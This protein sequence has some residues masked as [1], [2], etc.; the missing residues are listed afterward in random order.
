MIWARPPQ[1]GAPY[2]RYVYASILHTAGPA[3]PAHFVAHASSLQRALRDGLAAAA[4]PTSDT[5]AS[6]EVWRVLAECARAAGGVDT[7]N[8]QRRRG[9]RYA[10]K[11]K[12]LIDAMRAVGCKYSRAPRAT[13]GVRALY[14]QACPPLGRACG[15]ARLV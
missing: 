8:L 11:L 4:R 6:A 15:G 5:A 14:T 3:D 1:P 2:A 7:V 9:Q 13:N 10:G 12:A